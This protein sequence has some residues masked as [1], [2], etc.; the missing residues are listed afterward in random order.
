[1]G[2]TYRDV[3]AVANSRFWRRRSKETILWFGFLVAL[4]CTALI[5]IRPFNDGGSI[6]DMFSSSQVY[7][8]ESGQKVTITGANVRLD[9]ELLERD[10]PIQE[11]RRATRDLLIGFIP[12]FVWSGIVGVVYYKANKF[13]DSFARNWER[14]KEI[15]D[16]E[17]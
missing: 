3:R 12:L 2:L 11:G 8:S 5:L 1:M 4:I 10:S 7:T 17:D 15:P 13:K 6:T 16:P 14:T 9:G